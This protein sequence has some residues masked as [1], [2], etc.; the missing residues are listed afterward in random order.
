L[1]PR[2]N[3]F[4]ADSGGKSQK[5][6]CVSSHTPVYEPTILIRLKKY[7]RPGQLGS[8]ENCSRFVGCRLRNPRLVALGWTEIPPAD[9]RAAAPV[10]F[11]RVPIAPVLAAVGRI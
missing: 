1:E 10:P 5:N 4:S 6:G 7:L 11:F 3:N 9:A 8:R 2:E